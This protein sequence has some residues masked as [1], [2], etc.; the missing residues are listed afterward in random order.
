MVP[1]HD[2]DEGIGKARG[3]NWVGLGMNDLRMDG[4]NGCFLF[5]SFYCIYAA[6]D[7]GC[8][9]YHIALIH[10]YRFAFLLF[11]FA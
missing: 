7:F 5:C 10:V 6:K 9:F 3:L 1:M 2:W 4:N 8:H 11:A